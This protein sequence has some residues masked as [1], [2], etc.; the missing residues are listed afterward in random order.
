M[1]AY[2]KEKMYIV[3][4]REAGVQLNAEQA[5]WKDDTDDDSEEQEKKHLYVH[6]NI[7]MRL[8]SRCSDNSG[9][10]YD[11]EP[12][13]KDKT[14]MTTIMCL[15]WKMNILATELVMPYRLAEL[16]VT[17]QV[18]LL[19]H[20]YMCSGDMSRVNRDA[21]STVC[22][23]EIFV[24]DEKFLALDSIGRWCF[25][26]TFTSDASFRGSFG[27]LGMDLMALLDYGHGLSIAVL[28]LGKNE[29]IKL[30]RL[31]QSKMSFHQA[32]NLIFELDDAAVGCT[33]DILRQSDC[34]TGVAKSLGSRSS[35]HRRLGSKVLLV[36]GL[37]W[38]YGRENRT[39]RSQNPMPHGFGLLLDPLIPVLA[40][41]IKKSCFA[42]LSE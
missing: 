7:F 17:P 23:N 2:H 39:Q 24:F 21:V 11:D 18:S 29:Q 12:I 19:L 40:E 37:T 10:I 42:D 32:L 33:Q 25:S 4:Q 30:D 26:C 1:A 20:G 28:Q 16:R 5:A 14:I 36:T 13:H 27:W 34:L 38:S 6:G 22:E 8:Y 15:P 31:C 41:Q 35:Y 9:P 3:K